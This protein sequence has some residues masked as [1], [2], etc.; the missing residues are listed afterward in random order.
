[1]AD[2]RH[3]LRLRGRIWW[4]RY[5]RNGRRHE[6]S[7]GS[8]KKQAAIDLLKIREG[9]VAKGI[10]ISTKVGQLR[11]EEAARDLVND[12][13]I[14][15]KRPLDEIQRRLRLYLSPFFG[16]RRMTSIATDDVRAYVASR[17][18]Q[19]AAN[20]TINRELAAL[21]RMFSLASQ[22]GKV[23]HRPY[24]PMLREN[25]VRTGFFERDEY[26]AVLQKLSESIGPVV[27]FAY[28]TGWRIRSEILPLEWRQVDFHEGTVR[29]DVVTTKNREEAENRRLQRKLQRAETIITLQKKVAEILGIP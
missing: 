5:S 4:I 28:L 8:P 7:S 29:L 25:N 22:T 3:G 2:T 21:K 26:E 27:T 20:A 16:R 13:T 12:Y 19:G 18:T 24:I 17:H 23:L 11:F 9:D 1:M 14:N 6:E 15:G 10:P